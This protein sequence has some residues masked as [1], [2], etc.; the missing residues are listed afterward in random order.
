MTTIYYT[1]IIEIKYLINMIKYWYFVVVGCCFFLYMLDI[2]RFLHHLPLVLFLLMFPPYIFYY[3]D[4]VKELLD[5]RFNFL[6]FW[7]LAK[8][9]NNVRQ[10]FFL[11]PI[12]IYMQYIWYYEKKKRNYKYIAY[13]NVLKKFKKF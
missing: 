1:T 4:I 7:Y 6:I 9:I 5:L 11:P 10:D 8:K 12:Y 3:C 13:Y 2:T